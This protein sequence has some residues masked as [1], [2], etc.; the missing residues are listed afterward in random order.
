M[1]RKILNLA[2]PVS[3]GLILLGVTVT[4]LV[5]GCLKSTIKHC[6]NTAY[7][8]WCPNA[9]VCCTPGYAHYCDGQCYSTDCPSATITRDNCAPE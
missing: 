2:L 4:G 7:P 8:L 5:S 9:K 3:L 1:K 6:T